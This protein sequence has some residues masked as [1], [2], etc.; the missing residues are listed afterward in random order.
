M[1]SKR[2]VSSN[3]ETIF[4]EYSRLQ[5]KCL[6]S[7]TMT[8]SYRR[9]PPLWTSLCVTLLVW[10]GIVQHAPV[11]SAFIASPGFVSSPSGLD[12]IRVC[13]QSPPKCKAARAVVC[14]ATIVEAT[15]DLA[16]SSA[17]VAEAA[18]EDLAS[19]SYLSEIVL[20]SMESHRDEANEYAETFG[21]TSADAA[22]YALFAGIVKAQAP[23]GLKGSP[24]VL[25]HDQVV[26]ALHQE[27][28]WPG[29]FTMKDL[30][31]AVN[32][33]FLDAFRGST[34]NRKGWKSRDVAAPRGES[35]EDSRMTFEDVQA[36]LE[37]GTVIFNAA[38]A[39]IP[40]LAGSSLACTDAAVLPCALNLYVTQKGKRT[41]APP[42]TD[43][44]DVAVIQTSG[45]KH[46][47][48]Y[49]PPDPAFK[50]SADMFARGKADDNLPLYALESDLNCKLLLETTL[51][52]GDVLFIPAPFPHTTSTVTDDDN[53]E[54]EE[55]SIHLTINFDTHVL[56]LD[57]LSARRL[58]LRRAGV[59][60]TALG[61][62][63]DD[64][65]RYVG[66]VN[67]LPAAVRSDLF[68]ALP[69]QLL[70]DDAEKTAP[71]IDVMAKELERISRAVD[72]ETAS[73][74][75][76]SVWR[77]TAARFRQEGMELLEV[78]RAM[79]LAAIEEGQKRDAEVAKTG[80]LDQPAP[81]VLTPERIQRLSIFRVMRYFSELNDSITSLNA[82]SYEGKPSAAARDKA[83]QPLPENWAFTLP[84]AVGDQVEAN[85]IGAFFPATI[86]RASEGTYDVKYFDGDSETGMDR[87]M[88]MLLSPPASASDDKDTLNMTPN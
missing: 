55:T 3:L 57:Y 68:D 53:P 22:F 73:A 77:E 45:R 41:S 66:K 14:R 35:F 63:H 65:N 1:V 28:R 7:L 17:T 38:G 70:E 4:I 82:W 67:Q 44:Q 34:D 24:F 9:T 2:S 52:P 72:V 46:W 5:D 79:Y 39:H 33:D 71:L 86:T 29:F 56:G 80:H 31:R 42:H 60:D 87:S 15:E 51:N 32:D 25:R 30:E 26:K 69:A 74:V 59:L 12:S 75:D 16:A 88:I 21:L 48:V 8:V 50:P 37:K 43:K 20:N 27:S 47:R 23:F 11:V 6:T 85:Q 81:R 58:A 64:D 13:T 40:K 84:L 36:A 83:L 49:S 76:A 78:H 18:T 61:Q 62:T 10:K 54:S 19:S